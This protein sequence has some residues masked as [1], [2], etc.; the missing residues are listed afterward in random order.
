MRDSSTERPSEPKNTFLSGILAQYEYVNTS[1][2]DVP[3]FCL[4]IQIIACARP[5]LSVPP[6]YEGG[7]KVKK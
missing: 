7:T 2:S 5:S 3:N 4:Y 1:P 6:E